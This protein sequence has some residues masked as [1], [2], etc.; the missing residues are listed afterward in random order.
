MWRN[1][2]AYRGYVLATALTDLKS[3]YAGTA[4]GVLWH[5][6]HPA[7]VV[8]VL[9]IVFARLM[10]GRGGVVGDTEMALYLATGL[11]PWMA[12][13]DGITRGTNALTDNTQFLKKLAIPEEVFVARSIVGSGLYLGVVLALLFCFCGFTGRF[14][15]LCWL[16]MIA[17][18]VLALTMAFG[19][20][21]VLSALN[22]FVRDVGQIVPAVLQVA[23]WLMPVLYP[24]DLAPAALRAATPWLP[25]HP[26]LTAGREL[27]MQGTM[28][29]L[30][31][32]ITM[33]AWT[34]GALVA[35][36]AVLGRLR[37][38]VRDTL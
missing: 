10:P 27:L 22:V 17:V 36:A 21:L 2:L 30:I 28:P 13:T 23:M 16:A 5:I 4:L 29:P 20:S 34:G 26:F 24:A 7:T 18:S 19:F 11:L 37:R 35:G 33:A 1:L 3:R 15:P 12:F 25:F 38:G 9:G 31:S 14:Y 8:L 32:W 6:V